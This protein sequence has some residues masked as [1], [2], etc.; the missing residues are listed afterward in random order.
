MTVELTG[1]SPVII[2]GC[3]L[4]EE[5]LR[6]VARR[7][8]WGKVNNSGQVRVFGFVSFHFGK[9]FLCSILWF[10]FVLSSVLVVFR[11]VGVRCDGVK[12]FSHC[13]HRGR[14]GAASG[15]TTRWVDGRPDGI[16]GSWLYRGPFDV[17][18]TGLL[19]PEVSMPSFPLSHSESP[20]AG[21]PGFVRSSL[22]WCSCSEWSVCVHAGWGL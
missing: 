14:E 4:G 15:M 5:E 6:V 7:I 3:N 10:T 11:F 20:P 9:V 22:G 18:G 16:T 1:K 12:R 8:A 2:D 17:S 21:S 13:S 19:S